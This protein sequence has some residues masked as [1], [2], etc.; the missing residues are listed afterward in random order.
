MVV[1]RRFILFLPNKNE[2]FYSRERVLPL[3]HVN[4]HVMR[5]FS[6]A[7][8]FVIQR[9]LS[10][11]E[12]RFREL[13]TPSFLSA[14]VQI[15]NDGRLEV[16]SDDRDHSK[17]IIR[18]LSMVVNLVAY[19]L[20]NKLIYA[21]SI[22]INPAIYI[23]TLGNYT[24]SGRTVV[25]IPYNHKLLARVTL[26]H[27]NN[28]FDAYQ[29]LRELANNKFV[30]KDDRKHNQMVVATWM[31]IGITF[32]AS[33]AGIIDNHFS[34]NDDDVKE[35]VKKYYKLENIIN[36]KVARID[37]LEKQKLKTP[38]QTQDSADKPK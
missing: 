32:L 15:N 12:T 16:R 27:L 13:F 29:P 35:L 26:R 5:E 37:S 25:T 7:E 30:S 4:K 36:V 8:Q 21:Y 1:K 18:E 28:L 6:P 22:S 11:P 31:A 33:I 3:R 23:A 34:K 20:N 2:F 14:Q 24:G 17:A 9:I 38:L 10:N 19:L